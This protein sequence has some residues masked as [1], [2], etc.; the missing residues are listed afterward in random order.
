MA[1]AYWG[2]EYTLASNFEAKVNSSPQLS[3]RR[4]MCTL[5]SNFQASDKLII[6][7]EILLMR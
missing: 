1:K 3:T 2:L 5:A 4:L 6:S 7:V